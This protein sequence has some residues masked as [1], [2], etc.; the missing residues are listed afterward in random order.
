VTDRRRTFGPVVALG[1]AAGILATFAGS[2]P[3]VRGFDAAPGGSALLPDTSDAGE[4]PLAS[5][6]GLV[7]LACWGVL[8]VTRGVGRRVVATLALLVSVGLAVT[9]VVGSLTLE[10]QVF[11][12]MREAG[13]LSDTLG[14]ELTPWFWVA[15]LAG[16][17]SVV[18]TFLAVAWCPAW[19]EMGSRY[20]APG[21]AGAQTDR[22]G[23][24]SNIDLWKSLDEGRDP[25]A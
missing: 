6:L 5:A 9:V 13:A 12:A 22:E 25:T 3:W 14:T 10:D 18:L 1:L 2:R 11:E 15:S 24:R 19:P 20:D 7:V 16:P 17:A 4:M 23:E 21:A 8:L